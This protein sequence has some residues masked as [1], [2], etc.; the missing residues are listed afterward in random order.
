MRMTRETTDTG[1]T[2]ESAYWTGDIFDVERELK[3]LDTLERRW[4][5]KDV[6]YESVSDFAELLK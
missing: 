1:H 4:E 5:N 6:E 3:N 2:F